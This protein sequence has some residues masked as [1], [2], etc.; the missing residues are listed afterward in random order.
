MISHTISYL[1]MDINGGKMNKKILLG[2]GS[3]LILAIFLVGLVSAT[4]SDLVYS[5]GQEQVGKLTAQNPEA[6]KAL[7]MYNVIQSGN[8]MGLAQNQLCQDEGAK[9][10]CNM[11]STFQQYSS[12]TEILNNP[13]SYFQGMMQQ[14]ACKENPNACNTYSQIMQT[15]AAAQTPI[16]TAKAYATQ[17]AT[18]QLKGIMPKQIST[19]FS[20]KRYLDVYQLKPKKSETKTTEPSDPAKVVEGEVDTFADEDF[21]PSIQRGHEDECRIGFNLDATFGDIYDCETGVPENR[22]GHDLSMVLGQE[23]GMLLVGNKCLLERKG[24]GLTVTT[25]DNNGQKAVCFVKYKD[26]TFENIIGGEV[27]KGPNSKKIRSGIFQ[28]NDEG[29][30]TY[31]EFQVSEETEF[32]FADKKY[33][34]QEGTTVIINEEDVNFGFDYVKNQQVELFSMKNGQWIS[35][36]LV[37]PTIV[38]PAEVI[39]PVTVKALQ[40]GR[41]LVTGN[42]EIKGNVEDIQIGPKSIAEINGIEMRTTEEQLRFTQC[43]EDVRSG[44]WLNFCKR[45]NDNDFFA[46]G[47]GF[48][49]KENIPKGR[50]YYM[51]GGEATVR[52]QE[53]R[54]NLYVR[55]AFVRGNVVAPETN[56]YLKQHNGLFTI[57]APEQIE[58]MGF[59][60]NS[61]SDV[62]QNGA[63]V[64]QS[65]Q[66]AGKVPDTLKGGY[67]ES[68]SDNVISSRTYFEDANV[69]AFSQDD[70]TCLVNIG[71]GNAISAAAILDITGRVSDAMRTQIESANEPSANC[72]QPGETKAKAPT[73]EPAVLVELKGWLSK[74]L[75]IN[76][77]EV[78]SI[79]FDKNRMMAI[80]RSGTIYLADPWSGELFKPHYLGPQRISSLS[81]DVVS[82]IVDEIEDD[83]D[84]AAANKRLSEPSAGALPTGELVQGRV[85][86]TSSLDGSA[87]VEDK[88]R[89]MR[90]GG[91]KWGNCQPLGDEPCP[92]SLTGHWIKCE[93]ADGPIFLLPLEDSVGM[94]G[95]P[96]GSERIKE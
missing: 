53:T 3:V 9:E 14:Q 37:V 56:L 78:T 63:G 92:G 36:G 30:L 86:I 19:I 91:S 57:N 28:F 89:F 27:E 84:Y 35:S 26:G 59:S 79:T 48:A 49:F 66:G 58:M 64:W 1:Q 21:T 24:S 29:S 81:R 25:D 85:Y 82:Y 11:M 10:M 51:K 5:V 38:P 8:Y 47:N 31:A 40:D 95:C 55:S 50:Y 46:T 17:M 43:K 70:G 45:S 39:T 74:D 88:W 42:F 72:D 4:F 73:T 34:L 83:E 22:E 52:L 15:S 62:M 65:L 60:E 96:A 68:E 77:D 44:N 80:L 87:I 67:L 69:L 32:V 20:Y 6:Q 13:S 54:A 75:Y 2:L 16:E 12:Y 7:D 33:K 61:R 76:D 18:Q 90:R 71:E 94:E 41:Y 93:Q 23:P